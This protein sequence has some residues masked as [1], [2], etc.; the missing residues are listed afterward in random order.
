MELAKKKGEE[1]PEPSE[2]FKFMENQDK[3]ELNFNKHEKQNHCIPEDY[4]HFLQKNEIKLED[5]LCPITD[6]LYHWVHHSCSLWMPGPQVTPRTPVKMNK[7]DYSKFFTGCV[8][9]CKKGPN[10]G[11]VI[12]CTKQDC[13]IFFH[14]ECAKRANYCMEIEKKTGPSREKVYKIFCESHRPFK[15]IQEI[16][17]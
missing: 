1:P 9:C 13:K 7:L 5:K 8:I 14:V 4:C 3:F 10:I 11:A 15:I 17:D 6:S 2:I 12:K 16:N